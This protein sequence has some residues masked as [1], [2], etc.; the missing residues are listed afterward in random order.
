MPVLSMP[1]WETPCSASHARS[2]Q[3]AGGRAKAAQKLLCFASWGAD[4]DAA[5][6]AGLI[7]VQT[8]ATFK[9]NLHG[10]HLS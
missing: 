3:L 8:S 2:R 10:Q 9:E 4:Q 7:D 5:D 1:T 6:D